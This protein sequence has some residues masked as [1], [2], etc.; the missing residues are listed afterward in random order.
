MP[1]DESNVEWFDFVGRARFPDRIGDGH[2]AASAA[3][4]LIGAAVVSLITVL[5]L[6]ETAGRPLPRGR[7]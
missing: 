4:Y 1:S 3:F 5:T 2:R 7:V 6:R